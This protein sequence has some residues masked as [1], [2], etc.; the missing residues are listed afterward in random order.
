[1]SLLSGNRLHYLRRDL[2]CMDKEEL[3]NYI[4]NLTQ[5]KMDLEEDLYDMENELDRTIEQ[6]NSALG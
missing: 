2:E 6:L 5:E 4:L 3:I 1:M